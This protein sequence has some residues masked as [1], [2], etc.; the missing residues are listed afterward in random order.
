M[1][2]RC[3]TKASVRATMKKS[4]SKQRALRIAVTGGIGCGKTEVARLLQKRGAVVW[5]AD[6]SV[7]RL[8]RRGTPAHARIVRVFGP[9]VVRS[10]GGICRVALAQAVFADPMQRRKLEKILHPAVIREMR[11]WLVAQRQ[12]ERDAVGV[13]P[14]LFEV[15]LTRGWDA[16]WCIAADEK[17]ALRRLERRGVHTADARCRMRAQWPLGRKVRRADVVIW[18]NGTRRALAAQVKK[19][20]A[21]CKKEQ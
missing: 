15:G 20:W 4:E 17:I 6:E 10:D 21:M 7:H 2:W 1:C 19:L 14:L 16:I 5:D 13:V 12:A 9:A 11:A 3:V 8:L 18:N